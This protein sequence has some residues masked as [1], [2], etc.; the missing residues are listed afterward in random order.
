MKNL[1]L[2]SVSVK[3]HDF[4]KFL[5]KRRTL[6]GFHRSFLGE[7][8]VDPPSGC[9]AGLRVGRTSQNIFKDTQCFPY[10][11]EVYVE[12]FGIFDMSIGFDAHFHPSCQVLRSGSLHPLSFQSMLFLIRSWGLNTHVPKAKVQQLI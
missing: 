12:A 5:V 9:W 6:S 2:M 3:H 8:L 7:Y 1:I 11:L 10:L 4:D